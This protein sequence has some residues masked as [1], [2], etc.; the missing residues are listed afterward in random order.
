MPTSLNCA[1]ASRLRRQAADIL[2]DERQRL[3]HLERADHEEREIGR[4]REALA[5]EGQHLLA[6]E[7]GDPL[8][9]QRPGR[10]VGRCVDLL[11]ALAEDL[12]RRPAAIRD[13]RR[14]LALQHLELLRIVAGGDEVLVEELEPGFEVGRRRATRDALVRQRDGRS[15]AC[16]LPRE[17]LLEVLGLQPRQ[18]RDAHVVGRQRRL[19]EVVGLRRA[20]RRR[21]R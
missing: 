9:G 3:V 10:V 15:H 16:P 6:V 13:R 7:G 14:Q 21:V 18:A 19:L 5:V 20:M 8:G 17:H 12:A 1:A 11:D 4:V 2:G